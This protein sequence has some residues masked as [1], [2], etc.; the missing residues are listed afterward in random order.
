MESWKFMCVWKFC[1][2]EKVG[3]LKKKFG[4]KQGPS[5]SKLPWLN[6]AEEGD[7]RDGDNEQE[8]RNQ[9][10]VRTTPINDGWGRYIGRHAWNT[11][12]FTSPIHNQICQKIFSRCVWSNFELKFYGM[13]NITVRVVYLPGFFVRKTRLIIL[14]YWV[15]AG[16]G[17]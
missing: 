1:C 13:P 7:V 17:N 5:F 16:I 4:T 9:V 6:S 11:W 12:I 3:N 15:A 14:K 10:G 2:D 8:T